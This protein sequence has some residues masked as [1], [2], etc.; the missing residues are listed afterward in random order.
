MRRTVFVSPIDP[1][2]DFLS[3]PF[4]MDAAERFYAKPEGDA[5]LAS[6][7]DEVPHPPGDPR[8]DDIAIAIALDHLRAVTTFPLRGVRRRWAGLRTFA[9]D[10]S[11]V[12]GEATPGSGFWWLAGQGG[13]G[14]QIAPALARFVARSVREERQTGDDEQLAAT[15]S[16]ARLAIDSRQPQPS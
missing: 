13:Y 15:M 2:A 5:V 16:P 3:W 10:R 4:L 7:A 9:L 6:P 11:P 14:I 1:P 12:V 8:P